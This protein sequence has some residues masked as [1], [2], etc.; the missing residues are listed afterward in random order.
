MS[1]ADVGYVG[2]AV[3]TTEGDLSA[4]TIF[5]PANAFSFDSTNEYNTPSQLR[6]SRDKSIKMAG[7]YSVS[8]TMGLELVPR[9]IASLL[10][11]ALSAVG[12]VTS[13][14]YSGGGYQHVI[15]P[16]VATPTFAFESS[17]GD[18]LVMRYG[19]IR[20][21]TLDISATFGEIVTSTWGLEGTTRAKQGSP[22]SESYAQVSP[23][24]FDG[25]TVSR[26][27]ALLANV[28][29]FTWTLGNNIDRRG[30]LRATRSWR[31]TLLGTRD[32]GLTATMDFEND[33]DYDLFLAESE[34]ELQLK[35]VGDYITGSSGPKNTLVVD[36]PRVSYNAV[37]APLNAG[38]FIT[39]D[40]DCTIVRPLNGDPILTLTL[41]NS[42]SSVAGA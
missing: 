5:L 23:F 12:G 15:V 24:N 28:Q 33:D 2:Y 25:V 1:Y 37:N 21:N 19:G 13:S 4:P 27:D 3:E 29:N 9:G 22:T 11:S 20:V 32:V 42:E 34:F 26:D 14:P 35:F 30:T 6:G 36:I 40:I 31:R 41:V 10:V 7:P 16:G 39:Q 17:A 38:D 18:I 8:G